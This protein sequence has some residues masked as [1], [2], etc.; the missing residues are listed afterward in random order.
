[1][2]GKRACKNSGLLGGHGRSGASPSGCDMSWTRDPLEF[3]LLG[4]AWAGPGCA[5]P[6]LQAQESGGARNGPARRLCRV[7]GGAGHTTVAQ[8]CWRRLRAPGSAGPNSTRPA[9]PRP[10][11]CMPR[12]GCDGPGSAHRLCRAHGGAS[13]PGAGASCVAF[14]AMQVQALYDRLSW[15]RLRS[16]SSLGPGSVYQLCGALGEVSQPTS[17]VEQRPTPACLLQPVEQRCTR[18]QHDT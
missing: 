6:A 17:K 8:L 12:L 15:P 3:N 18:M 1:M 7:P 4:I 14:P 2:Q 13:H 10:K 9:V 16:P 11:L 5:P